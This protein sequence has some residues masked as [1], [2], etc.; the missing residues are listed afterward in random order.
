MF[1]KQASSATKMGEIISMGIPLVTN[2]GIG[3]SDTIMQ[4]S[5]VGVLTDSQNYQAAIDRIT[6]GPAIPAEQIRTAACTYFS[7][8]EG[9]AA[10]G[11]V[12]QQLTE[13]AK[14]R[15]KQSR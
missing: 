9:V 15:I 7:L 8:P 13:N 1:S 6:L 2:R 14:Y 10:Y 4:E 11:E 3:D 5:G 12:Y